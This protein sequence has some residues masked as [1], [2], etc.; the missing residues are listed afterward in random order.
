[1]THTEV[2][3]WMMKVEYLLTDKTGTLTQNQMEFRQCSINGN[4]YVEKDGR[5]WM[6]TDNSARFLHDCENFVLEYFHVALQNILILIIPIGSLKWS[7]SWWHWHY[8]IRWGSART[9]RITTPTKNPRSRMIVSIIRAPVPMK[10]HSLKPA[11]GTTIGSFTIST[12]KKDSLLVHRVDMESKLIRNLP[13]SGSVWFIA[14]RSTIRT[15]WISQVKSETIRFC[16]CLNSIRV[17]RGCRL[18][19]AFLTV[20]FGWFAKVLKVT[21]YLSAQK[22]LWKIRCCISTITLW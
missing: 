7:N 6:A 17:A 20:L 18:S 3:N 1:M 4:K 2:S 21:W 19:L 15:L 10:K 13:G 11:A 8:V 9:G 12:A 14:R 22:D 5:L 16:K